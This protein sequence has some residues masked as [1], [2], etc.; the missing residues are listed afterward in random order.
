MI[1]ITQTFL[2]KAKIYNTTTMPLDA[3]VGAFKGFFLWVYL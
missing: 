3:V 1:P 2:F